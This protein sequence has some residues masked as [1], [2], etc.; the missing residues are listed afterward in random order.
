[1]VDGNEI[2]LNVVEQALKS[3]K[4]QI[5]VVAVVKDEKHKASK[6]LGDKNL[7]LSYRDQILLANAEAHRF[8]L[9]FH[10]QKRAKLR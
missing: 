4:I 9:A 7:I 3:L 6:I 1:V 2:Q 10:R 5:P 8:A